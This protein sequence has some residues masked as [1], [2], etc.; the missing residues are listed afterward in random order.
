MSDCSEIRLHEIKQL[1]QLRKKTEILI[2]PWLSKNFKSLNKLGGK[3]F[4][5]FSSFF[6]SQFCCSFFFSEFISDYKLAVIL[7]QQ[8]SPSVITHFLFTLIFKGYYRN[9]PFPLTSFF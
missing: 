8:N 1:H 9:A 5:Q 3:K 6:T 4:V 2:I 7:S